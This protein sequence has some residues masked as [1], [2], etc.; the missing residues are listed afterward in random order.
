MQEVSAPWKAGAVLVCGNER[1]P[2][3]KKPSCG[4]ARAT[5]LRQWLKVQLVAEGLKGEVIAVRT[6]CLGVCSALGVTVAIC[7]AE[8]GERRVFVVDPVADRAEIW[9]MAKHLLLK[10]SVEP[11]EG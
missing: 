1:E 9:A 2:G 3:A 11:A 5:E 8:D 7:P 10:P 4:L 6:G